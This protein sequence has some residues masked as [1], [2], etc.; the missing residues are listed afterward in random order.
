[1]SS[2]PAVTARLRR[3]VAALILTVAVLVSGSGLTACSTGGAGGTAT[4]AR[5][6]AP[7]DQTDHDAPASPDT[8]EDEPDAGDAPGGAPSPPRPADPDASDVEDAVFPRLGDPRIDILHHEVSVRADPNDETVTGSVTITLR[9]ITEDPLPELTLD[10]SGPRVT[11]AVIDGEPAVVRAEKR[12]IV[13]TPAEPLEPDVDAEIVLDYEGRPETVA[14]SGGFATVGWQ[15]DRAGGWFSMAEPNGT[16]T[17][18]PTNDHPADKSTWSFTL[19]VP[20][21]WT[22]IANGRLV[23]DERAGDRRIWRWEME[24][25]IPPHTVLVA[26]GEY[27]LHQRTG[28]D[29]IRV[30]DAIATGLADHGEDLAAMAREG[31]RIITELARRYGPYPYRDA[32]VIV[33]DQEMGVALE[34]TTRPLFDP[35]GLQYALTH[36]LAHQWF[37]DAV[38]PARWEDLW[39]AESFATYADWVW[40]DDLDLN[41]L[42]DDIIF[43][44]P[45]IGSAVTDPSSAR[46]FRSSIYTGGATA[47]HAL[48]RTIGDDDFFTALRRFL[49]EHRHGNASTNDLIEAFEDESG[50][51]LGAWRRDWLESPVLPDGP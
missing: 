3:G 13:L 10:L 26:V 19:D 15:P 18:V 6:G 8:S 47:L 5:P 41:P 20:A 23:G 44:D 39:F 7:I 34:T 28:P 9:A 27:E 49:D 40:E 51:D 50:R 35:A 12:Q 43:S 21:G 16:S 25:P 48:R 14:F 45:E 22:G 31:D 32:G 11:R 4:E 17:W 37:G 1:M 24:E 29:G 33:V 42:Q 30:I 36:E 38:T 2:D 46:L